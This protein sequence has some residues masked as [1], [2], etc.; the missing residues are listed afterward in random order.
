VRSGPGAPS[1]ATRGSGPAAATCR[2]IQRVMTRSARP[3][4]W[5]LCTWVRNS[6][7]SSDGGVPAS[8]NR[9][10][11]AR[12]ASNCRATSP[13]RTSVPAPAVPGRGCGTPVPV[14]TTSV[15]MRRPTAP[16]PA[17]R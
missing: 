17:G 4:T 5:S 3:T 14:S 8:I 16:S 11:V 13:L 6:A 2:S 15:L 12:P 10:T 9:R 7:V 1:G